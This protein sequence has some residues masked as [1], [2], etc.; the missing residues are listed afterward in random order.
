MI[1]RCAADS[2]PPLRLAVLGDVA[3]NPLSRTSAVG[4][5]LQLPRKTVDRV[6]QELH[7]LGLLRIEE[8]PWGESVRWLYTLDT[9]VDAEVLGS[10]TR[11]ARNVSTPGKENRANDS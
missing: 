4:R 7:L 8:E 1:L 6:L 2:V 5:R 9:S 3:H 10:L 11:V